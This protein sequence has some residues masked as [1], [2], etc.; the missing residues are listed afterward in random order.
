MGAAEKK[1]ETVEMPAERPILFKGEMVRAILAGQK[2]QTRR[3][4]TAR[5]GDPNTD[6]DVRVLRNESVGLQAF[7]KKPASD[8][9]HG[10]GCPF[11]QVGDRLWVRETLRLDGATDS[12]FYVADDKQI[13]LPYDAHDRV[14]AMRAWVHH[15]EGH[16]CPSIHMPRWASRILLE[17]TD[18]RVE[19]LQSISEDDAKAEGI[20]YVPFATIGAERG[21]NGP[22]GLR[23]TAA[24]AFEDLWDSI[25]GKRAPWASNPW[26]WVVSFKRVEGQH[27]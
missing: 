12:W 13:L 3:L 9:W 26:L 10:V 14:L 2:T 18:V 24:Q 19:Q 4:V 11:G 6:R 17:V 16:S 21:Y 22:K 25:N 8:D 20:E 7:F 27:G 23:T 5:G 15:K 1:R